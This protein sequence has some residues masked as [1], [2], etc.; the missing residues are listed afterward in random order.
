MF[1]TIN[2]QCT[3]HLQSRVAH[4]G[5][6]S[7]NSSNLRTGKKRSKKPLN[8]I[9]IQSSQN[10]FTLRRQ[11]KYLYGEMEMGL[12]SAVWMLHPLIRK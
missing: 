1:C 10:R 7:Y 8:H 9:Q 4:S 11:C 5:K 2:Y 12:R 6:D 3:Q